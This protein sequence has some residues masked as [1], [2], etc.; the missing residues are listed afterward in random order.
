[1]EATF[2]TAGVPLRVKPADGGRWAP[3]DPTGKKGG[4]IKRMI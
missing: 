1:M 2:I 3:V 4:K